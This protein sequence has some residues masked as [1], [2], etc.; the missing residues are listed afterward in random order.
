MTHDIGNFVIR[1]T[2]A[3]KLPR[4]QLIHAWVCNV[5]SED[6]KQTLTIGVNNFEH[7]T[8]HYQ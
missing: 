5:R 1:S 4:K 8:H 2:D 6:D 7:Y 3:E